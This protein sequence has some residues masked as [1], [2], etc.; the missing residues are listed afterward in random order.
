MWLPNL[1]KRPGCELRHARAFIAKGSEFVV[2]SRGMQLRLRTSPETLR[3][4]EERGVPV[5]VKETQ[6][7]VA[8]YNELAET[9]PVGGLFH[10][11]C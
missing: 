3:F 2:L 7:A 6:E 4:L 9:Q 11:T 8:L 1:A 10:T 5:H